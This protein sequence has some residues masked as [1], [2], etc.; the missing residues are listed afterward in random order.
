MLAIERWFVEASQP[1]YGAAF[2]ASGW[3]GKYGMGFRELVDRRM[4]LIKWCRKSVCF[5]PFPVIFQDIE[6]SSQEVRTELC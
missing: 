3:Y 2:V 4:Q 1:V 6:I 5:L